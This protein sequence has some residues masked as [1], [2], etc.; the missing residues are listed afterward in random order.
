[1]PTAR[2]VIKSVGGEGQ[3]HDTGEYL[4]NY[5]DVS[6]LISKNMNFLL[7]FYFP[8]SLVNL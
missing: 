2:Q 3:L 8:L 1:M 6:I 5:L 7:I 4:H